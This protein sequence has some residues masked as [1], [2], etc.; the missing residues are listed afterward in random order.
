MSDEL[1][2]A[3][4]ASYKIFLSNMHAVAQ[5]PEDR[6]EIYEELK[7]LKVN[8]KQV[9]EDEVTAQ[10]ALTLIFA[11]PNISFAVAREAFNLL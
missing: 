3:M 10:L 4:T 1:L 8:A 2:A 7:A 11:N 6:E 9:F 5:E